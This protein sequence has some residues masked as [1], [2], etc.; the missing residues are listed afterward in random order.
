MIKVIDVLAKIAED[1]SLVKME[2]ISVFVTNSDVSRKQQDAII[3]RDS[4]GLAQT[5]ND[6][7]ISMCSVIHPAESEDQEVPS[8]NDNDESEKALSEAVNH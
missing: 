8:E 7:P 4:D 5:I 2:D 6:F 3:A 1:A